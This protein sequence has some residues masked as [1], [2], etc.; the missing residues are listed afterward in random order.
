MLDAAGWAAGGDGIR[1]KDGRRASFTL[2]YPATDSLRKELPLAVTADAK[3]AGIE[4]K[5]EGLTSDA[6]TPRMKN[7]ALIMGYGTPYDPDFVSYKLF[8]SAFA[9]EGYYNPGSYRS[10]VVDKVL[11]DGRDHTA[12]AERQAAY[13]TFQKQPSRV[14]QVLWPTVAATERASPTSSARRT[15]K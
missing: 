11:Q 10:A 5:P 2:M 6:I 3:K 15:A 13:A 8:G 1:A 12:T 7:D 4:I 14:G 9:E